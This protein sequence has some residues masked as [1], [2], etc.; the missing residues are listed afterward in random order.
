[1]EMTEDATTEALRLAE[2]IGLLDSLGVWQRLPNADDFVRLISLAREPAGGP[3]DCPTCFKAGYAQAQEDA[4]AVGDYLARAP[5]AGWEQDAKRWQTIVAM[6][7]EP[8][9]RQ[10][11]NGKFEYETEYYW[12][13]A[14]IGQPDF[15][16]AIDAAIAAAPNAQ[17]E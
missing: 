8:S 9:S 4:A 13:F 5:Q 2:Q 6:L 1:M 12:E 15:T 17:E 7:G 11:L 14:A 10:R 3:T 16:L